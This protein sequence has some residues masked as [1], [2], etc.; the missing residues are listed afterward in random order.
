MM[1]YIRTRILTML[2][3]K[4]ITQKELATRSKLSYVALNKFLSK[5]K[6]KISLDTLLSIARG[7]NIP[8]EFLLEQ[9]K[10]ESSI[11]QETVIYKINQLSDDERRKFL[12][13][14]SGN[15][16]LLLDRVP[17][18]INTDDNGST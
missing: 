1:D 18:N 5:G 14:V 8:V 6:D 13:I 4:N 9:K 3:E 12:L 7:L 17:A 10:M 15:L 11:L 2:E 16:D